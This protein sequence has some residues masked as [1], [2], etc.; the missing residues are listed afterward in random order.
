MSSHGFGVL[1]GDPRRGSGSSRSRASSIG[2]AD[3]IVAAVRLAQRAAADPRWACPRFE[4][5]RAGDDRA[6]LDD[7]V[8]E[9]ERLHEIGAAAPG[10]EAEH[11]AHDAQ[12]VAATFAR[13]QVEFHLV[14]EK[15]QADFVAVLH[16]REGEHARDLPPPA[17]ACFCVPEPKSP[18]AL[19]STMRRSVSSRSSTNF[20][21]NGRPAR[22]VTFQSIVRTSSPGT[23]FA[24][25]A[26][27]F[28]PRPLKTLLVLAGRVSVTSRW[29]RISIWRTFLR[30]SRVCS[31]VIVG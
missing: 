4:N 8:H 16:R 9:I 10:L 1:D 24:H 31:G 27:K 15:Q 18:D 30:M 5:P 2:S 20:F 25:Y 7:V 19:T 22:A 12:H 6:A 14:G 23:V 11:F 17:R 21:T 29:V 3:E 26:S 28:M 13:R